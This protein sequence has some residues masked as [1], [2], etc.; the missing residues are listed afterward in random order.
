M[1]A[2]ASCGRLLTK[3]LSLQPRIRVC[4]CLEALV[5]ASAASC[6]NQPG[7]KDVSL[8][9][10]SFESTQAEDHKPPIVILHG[11]FGSK[12]NWK[13]LSKA[14]VNATKRVHSRCPQSWRKPTHGRHG[15]HTNGQ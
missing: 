9:F 8:S 11:L 5:R 14:M 13:S 10:A 12:N 15:L 3:R 1:H 4:G 2:L 7:S 6:G